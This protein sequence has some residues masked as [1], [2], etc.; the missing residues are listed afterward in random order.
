MWSRQRQNFMDS[1][2]G[3]REVDNYATVEEVKSTAEELT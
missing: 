3:F 1:I 2:G